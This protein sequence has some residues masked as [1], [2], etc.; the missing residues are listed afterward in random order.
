MSEAIHVLHPGDVAVAQRGE[1][2]E[3]LLGSCVAII[4]TDPRRT[5]AAM[6]HIVHSSRTAQ[7]PPDDAAYADVALD[8]MYGLLRAKG[9]TP[10]LCQA[11]V[12]GGGNMFPEHYDESTVGDSNARWALDAMARDGVRI[13]HHD[14]GGRSY[15][16]LS[17]QV[18][19]AAPQVTAVPV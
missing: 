7:S 3:T 18:G 11:Y 4:L 15:R 5:V 17:W 14:L 16:R 6:C 2:L 9:I 10:T 8:S 12:Y 13:V 19:P 1:K